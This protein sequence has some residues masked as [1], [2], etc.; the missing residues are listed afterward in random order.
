MSLSLSNLLFV[1]CVSA[2][3]VKDPP[4]FIVIRTLFSDSSSRTHA[5]QSEDYRAAAAEPFRSRL[6][7]LRAADGGGRRSAG[8]AAKY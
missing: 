1:Y 7:R 4:P 5:Y 8:R 6:N 2:S 3:K